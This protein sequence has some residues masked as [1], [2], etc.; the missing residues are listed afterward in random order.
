MIIDKIQI[1]K[2]LICNLKYFSHEI[3]VF[4]TIINYEL[5]L[6][7]LRSFSKNQKQESNLQQVGGLVTK[8]ISFYSLWR[9]MSFFKSISYQQISKN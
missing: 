3:I 5:A 9:A 4:T 2:I 6:I 7:L 8:N 1:S